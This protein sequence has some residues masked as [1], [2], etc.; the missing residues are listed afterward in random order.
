MILMI[1]NVQNVVKCW[2]SGLKREVYCLINVQVGQN[3]LGSARNA[4]VSTL[5]EICWE[6]EIMESGLET[7]RSF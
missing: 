3:S 7:C 5:K 6:G 1:Q 4:S 2:S